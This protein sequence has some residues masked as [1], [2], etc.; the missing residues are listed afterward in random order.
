MFS[1]VG[2]QDR[3]GIVSSS[4]ETAGSFFANDIEEN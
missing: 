4:Y 2:F 1:P 3:M